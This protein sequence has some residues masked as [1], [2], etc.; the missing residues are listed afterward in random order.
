[1][2]DDQW[3]LVSY[4]ATKLRKLTVQIQFEV[5]QLATGRPKKDRLCKMHSAITELDGDRILSGLQYLEST[6]VNTFEERS[7]F[8]TITV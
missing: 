5:D 8:A 3:D 6:R 1:M 7:F 2:R 4:D